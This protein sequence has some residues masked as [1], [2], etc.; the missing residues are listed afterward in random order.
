MRD[1][2]A[3]QESST[4]ALRC[5]SWTHLAGTVAEPAANVSEEC[6][7]TGMEVGSNET[8]K[9]SVQAGLGLGLLLR[10]TISQEIELTCL[11]K[12]DVSELPIMRHWYAVNRRGKRL[13]GAAE[14][15]REFLLKEARQA[16]C[17]ADRN[18]PASPRKPSKPRRR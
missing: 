7:F 5:S 15:F 3:R 14:A 10:V 1:G 4:D 17:D 2:S 12:L 16:L 8:I 11:V 13:S 9:Q 6:F 18:A